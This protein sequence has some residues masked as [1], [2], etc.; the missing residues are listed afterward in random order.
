MTIVTKEFYYPLLIHAE[1]LSA[2]GATDRL[3]IGVVPDNRIWVITSIAWEDDDN[4]ITSSLIL[5]RRGK[6]DYVLHYNGALTADVWAFLHDRLYLSEGTELIVS[7]AGATASDHLNVNVN[8]YVVFLPPS[9]P[10]MFGKMGP[11]MINENP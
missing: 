8:G 7:F 9:M 4:N 5:T 10:D 1:M 6:T 11:E 3:S 2:G